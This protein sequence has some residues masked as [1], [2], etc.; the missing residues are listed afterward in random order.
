LHFNFPSKSARTFRTTQY[1]LLSIF[2]LTAQ[3]ESPDQVINDKSYIR[4]L[5]IINNQ[6]NE[7]FY[8][9]CALNTLLELNSHIFE[10]NLPER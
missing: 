8:L 6:Y 3:C 7:L 10:L 9:F 5:L 2:R 1:N 4:L